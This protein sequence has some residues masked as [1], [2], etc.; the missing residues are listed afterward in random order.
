VAS[1]ALAGEGVVR[2]AEVML[3]GG[4]EEEVAAVVVVARRYDRRQR[5][6]DGPAVPCHALRPFIEP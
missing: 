6:N 4:V 3:G 5:P 1:V 2:G